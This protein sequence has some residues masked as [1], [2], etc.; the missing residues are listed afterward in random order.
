M[1]AIVFHFNVPDRLAYASR[2]ARQALR[3]EVMLTITASEQELAE[4]DDRLWN[5]AP[6]DFVAHCRAPQAH[7]ALLAASRIVLCA[8]PRLGL[9]EGVLLTLGTQLPV[10]FEQFQRVVE[11]VSLEEDDRAQARLRWRQYVAAGHAVTRH[12]AAAGAGRQ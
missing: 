7:E 9:P 10:G 6:S 5:L 8:D 1:T 3:R 11:V 2:L 4:L 12:D